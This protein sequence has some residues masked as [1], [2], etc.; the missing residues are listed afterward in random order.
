MR[1]VS[2]SLFSLFASKNPQYWK[3]IEGLEIVHKVWGKCTIEKVDIAQRLIIVLGRN[4]ALEF[5]RDDV[6]DGLFLPSEIVEKISEFQKQKTEEEHLLKQRRIEEESKRLVREA[7]RKKVQLEAEREKQAE[8]Y[9]LLLEKAKRLKLQRDAQIEADR[10]ARLKEIEER[11]KRICQYCSERGILHLI[12]FTRISNL[13][14]ILERG[15]LNREELSRSPASQ[16][17]TFSDRERIDGHTDAVCL[18][19]SFPN[20]K[21]FYR[22]SS[23]NQDVWC[24]LVISPSVLWELDCAFCHSNAASSVISRISLQQL[25]TFEALDKMF[26]NEELVSRRDLGIPTNYPIDPQAEVLV[27]NRIPTNYFCSVHFSSLSAMRIWQRS[28]RCPDNIGLIVSNQYFQP[29][30]DWTKWTKSKI[31]LNEPEEFDQIPY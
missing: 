15:L 21:M 2:S 8:A 20:Y 17:I 28:N 25:R 13:K 22:L 1:S 5:F 18:S 19:I 6:F 27:F 4:V 9:R 31:V 7:V 11:S 12:H 26:R 14:S 3:F 30:C 10:Q 29:R 16:D 24:M 23:S